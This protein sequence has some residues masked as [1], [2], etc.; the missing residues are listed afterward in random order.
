MI[1]GGSIEEIVQMD[2][3]PDFLAW[4]TFGVVMIAAVWAAATGGEN[5]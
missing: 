4:L 5:A 1:R 3:Q 2:W